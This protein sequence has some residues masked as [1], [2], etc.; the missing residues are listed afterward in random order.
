MKPVLLALEQNDLVNFDFDWTQCFKYSIFQE[1]LQNE[2]VPI[3][4]VLKKFSRTNVGNRSLRMV[5][6]RKLVNLKLQFGIMDPE[7]MP[8]VL[9]E[10]YRDA[11]DFKPTPNND[12]IA[13]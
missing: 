13:D 2:I 5:L 1:E 12:D 6:A 11:A 9:P 10:E 7:E 4:M 8:I 3:I